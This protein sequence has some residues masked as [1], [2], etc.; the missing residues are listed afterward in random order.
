MAHNFEWKRDDGKYINF[1]IKIN[2]GIDR[3]YGYGG[4]LICNKCDHD[5]KQHY[6]C[7]NCKSHFTIGELD[8][9]KDKDTELIYLK[10]Q[11]KEFMK[12][13]TDDTLKVEMEV[14]INDGM[15]TLFPFFTGDFYEL[16]NNK[17][18][19]MA[20]QVQDYKSQLT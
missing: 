1:P 2:K 20:E 5:V 4:Q 3:D 15:T 9:R 8:K 16:H 7:D 17:M 18:D 13:E 6:Y 10:A 12:Q 11:K 19:I 14:E